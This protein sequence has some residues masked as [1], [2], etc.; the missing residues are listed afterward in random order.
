MELPIEAF[1]IMAEIPEENKIRSIRSQ[2]AA[3]LSLPGIS[4]FKTLGKK[5][6]K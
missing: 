4:Y 1:E 2:E 5:R 3:G 6:R